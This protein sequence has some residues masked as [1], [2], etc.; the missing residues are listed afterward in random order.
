M[1]ELRSVGYRD[2]TEIISHFIGVCLV[3]VGF[4]QRYPEVKLV[5]LF[6]PGDINGKGKV[7]WIEK[8]RF[9]YHVDS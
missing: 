9:F 4:V 1:K 8:V 2:T 7:V 5:K 6:P 3:G